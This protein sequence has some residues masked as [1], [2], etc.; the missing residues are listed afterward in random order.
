VKHR[1]LF[2]VDEGVFDRLT[3]DLKPHVRS[4]IAILESRAQF[5]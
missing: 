5:L 2:E 1:D 3:S 4:A